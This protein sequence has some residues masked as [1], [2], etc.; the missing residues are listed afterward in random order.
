MG[1]F[2]FHS[3]HLFFRISLHF[4][5]TF[6]CL[7]FKHS[8]EEA[9]EEDKEDMELGW[10]GRRKEGRKLGLRKDISLSANFTSKYAGYLGHKPIAALFGL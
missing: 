5:Y 1:N 4:L 3:S 2:G 8:F 6:K 7:K 9:D 10:V